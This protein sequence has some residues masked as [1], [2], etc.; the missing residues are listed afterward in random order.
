MV[1]HI[2]LLDVIHSFLR[3]DEVL[4]RCNVIL[5]N[6]VLKVAAIH[7]ML[8]GSL[9]VIITRWVIFGDLVNHFSIS[10][11]FVARELTTPGG[12]VFHATFLN[13]GIRSQRS[14]A[15]SLSLNF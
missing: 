14:F 10:L 2:V 12:V 15:S 6:T 13:L 3:L 4:V 11:L 9:M 5:V 8:L 1:R 7:F